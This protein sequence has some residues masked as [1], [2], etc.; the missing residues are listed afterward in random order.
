MARHRHP[1]AAEHD[2]DACVLENGVEQGRELPIAV[3][4]EEPRSAAS[5]FEVN[6]DVFRCLRHPRGGWVRGR[7]QDPDSVPSALAC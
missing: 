1:D 4:D 2:V 7:A 5:V 3:P 6:D